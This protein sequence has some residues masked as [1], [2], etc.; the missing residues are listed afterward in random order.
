MDQIKIGKFIA[1][2]RKEKNMT[3][4]QLAD[5][6]EISDKT[7]SK[8]ECGKGLPEVQFMIPLCDLLGINVNELLSGEK[9]SAD[10][11][12]KKAEENMITLVKENEYVETYKPFIGWI[13]S[14]VVMA[15]FF[16]FR[17]NSLG[18]DKILS[19]VFVIVV[20]TFIDVL[21][22]II[23]KGEYVY[24]IVYGPNF[25][26]AKNSDS[27]RRKTYAWKYLRIFLV[28]SI[29]LLIYLL[30][31]IYFDLSASYDFI[32]CLVIII[33]AALTTVPI[34]F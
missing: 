33:A 10:E 34:K 4:R 2:C 20:M 27:Q 13:I 3:Q 28:A 16:A 30:G 8:W 32:V 9:L 15:L 14:F 26:T 12:Q 19:K 1:N 29:I 18:N 21:F 24:W 31:S 22:S 17:W 11:Y 5:I 25:E 7:I 6:L 23:F